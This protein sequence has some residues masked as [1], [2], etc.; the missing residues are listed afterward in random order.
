MWFLENHCQFKIQLRVS[1]PGFHSE[2]MSQSEPYI[3]MLLG[4]VS[5]DPVHGAHED[6]MP[7]GHCS[8]KQVHGHMA[9]AT[10]GKSACSYSIRDTFVG[11]LVVSPTEL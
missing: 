9:V 11:R 1:R 4:T 2:G 10:Q 5:A 8:L 3:A 6:G 7:V